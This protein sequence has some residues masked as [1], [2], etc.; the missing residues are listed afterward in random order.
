MVAHS[1]T[2]SALLTLT[3]QLQITYSGQ[4]MS[5]VS[6]SAEDPRNQLP[7][8]RI[9][10]VI[11]MNLDSPSKLQAA[12]KRAFGALLATDNKEYL[13]VGSNLQFVHTLYACL[14]HAPS[15]Q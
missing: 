9:A 15:M 14:C 12:F 8:A 1:F 2:L 4:E 3:M 5:M 13:D 7:R 11:Q 10:H 6:I